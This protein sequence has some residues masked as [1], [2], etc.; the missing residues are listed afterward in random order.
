MLIM[1]VFKYHLNLEISPLPHLKSRTALTTRA[2][3]K[4]SSP[5]AYANLEPQ[6]LYMSGYNLFSWIQSKIEWVLSWPF[7]QSF[8]LILLTNKHTELKT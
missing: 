8:F 4:A 2:Q 5:V 6:P 1:F 7:P 3:T